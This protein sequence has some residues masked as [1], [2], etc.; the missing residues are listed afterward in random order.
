MTHL[1]PSA[2]KRHRLGVSRA[3]AL[4]ILCAVGT[5]TA[6][7]NAGTGTAESGAAT[8]QRLWDGLA[9]SDAKKANKALLALAAKGG[10]GAAFLAKRL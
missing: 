3:A 6:A 9:D 5:T 2:G 1:S 8:L 4:A 10:R 7:G